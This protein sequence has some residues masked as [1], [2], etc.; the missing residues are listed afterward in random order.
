M[1]NPALTVGAQIVETL[2][3]HAERGVS[4]RQ[5]L[6]VEMLSLVGIPEPSSAHRQYPHE[7]SGGMR[8][9]IMLA[10][11]LA[12]R[13]ATPDRGRADQRARRDDSGSGARFAGRPAQQAG[14]ERWSRSPMTSASSPSTAIGLSSCMRAGCRDRSDARRHRQSAPSL[15]PRLD[16]LNT[17]AF[18]SRP[19]I[20][21]IEGQVPE[22]VG[23]G[24][25]CRFASRCQLARHLPCKDRNA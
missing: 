2:K 14:H 18:R 8:Q 16:R 15:Y 22:L 4:P 24:D 1:L 20:T 3:E 5:A 13:P 11:A 7:F 10:I 17:P 9:R 19:S 23:L 21:P 12:C 25:E 6:G